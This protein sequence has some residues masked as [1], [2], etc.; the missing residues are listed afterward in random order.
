MIEVDRTFWLHRRVL[1]T[2]HTGFKG[3]WLC[4][5]LAELG[6]E[7]V[8]YAHPPSIQS[9]LHRSAGLVQR[10]ISVNGDIRDSERL[11]QLIAI[12]EPEIIFHLAGQPLVLRSLK[13]PVETFD[14]NT[15]GTL[16]LLRA[17]SRSRHLRAVVVVTS[18]KCYEPA[19]LPHREDDRLGGIDPYS[20]SKAAAEII[21]SCF[22]RC[23]LTPEDGTGIATA[24][25]GNVIGGGDFSTNRLMPDLVRAA[26]TGQPVRIR[27]PE[28]T[29]PWQHVL[30][31]LRGYMLLAEALARDPA[32]FAGAW[33]FG[34]STPAG[35]WSVGRVAR[36]VTA[37]FGGS[38]EIHPPAQS[39]ETATLM[40]DS[41]KAARELGY[42]PWLDTAAAIDFTLDGYRRL[43]DAPERNWLREQ[44]ADYD[45]L[46]AMPAQL[47]EAD[48][49]ARVLDGM[50]RGA[51]RMHVREP[52]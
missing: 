30:D 35:C 33:N 4:A 18:D 44:I 41:S 20:A 48:L 23:F 26:R 2:G 42:E 29:R 37:R 47:K 28:A 34:P 16:N 21:A 5:C 50:R 36:A 19:T 6:A 12:R 43:F 27:H 13:D 3:T 8:G 49:A 24:R 52:S 32:R 15:M 45:D 14:I 7:L 10:M 51:G 38:V 22:S 9:L 25:A 31:V 40:L 11:G 46:T 39:V 17:A 1:V